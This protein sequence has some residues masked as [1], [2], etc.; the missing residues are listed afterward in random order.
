MFAGGAALCVAAVALAL[1]DSRLAPSWLQLIAC[2]FVVMIGA[3]LALL[4]SVFAPAPRVMWTTGSAVPPELSVERERLTRPLASPLPFLIAAMI[5]LVVVAWLVMTYGDMRLWSAL[6]HRGIEVPAT[7]TKRSVHGTRNYAGYE[8]VGVAATAHI[9]ETRTLRKGD[10]VV[11][12]MLRGRP[13]VSLPF[14]RRELTWTWLADEVFDSSFRVI[15]ALLGVTAVFATAAITAAR[16]RTVRLVRDGSA[17]IATITSVQGA[18]VR[19]AFDS[20]S[21]RETRTMTVRSD[22]LPREGDR[23]V[24]LYD[25]ARPSNNLPWAVARAAMNI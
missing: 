20:P 8:L 15:F 16:R 3:L 17:T 2:V 13:A 6:R 7:I 24:V 23:F 22:P 5:A 25:P 14:A 18:W 19:Y 4:P 9:P 10:R 11:A 1:N 12:T 21:G